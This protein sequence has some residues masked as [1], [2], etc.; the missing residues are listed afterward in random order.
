MFHRYANLLP[1]IATDFINRCRQS[2]EAKDEDGEDDTSWA[3]T[4]SVPGWTACSWVSF[5]LDL[6]WEPERSE[7]QKVITWVR[8]QAPTLYLWSTN[9]GL[10]QH[11]GDDD[12]T[13]ATELADMC[14]FA[15]AM[16]ANS[17]SYVLIVFGLDKMREAYR[18]VL[19]QSNLAFKAG[20]VQSIYWY[21]DNITSPSTFSIDNNMD[22]GLVAFFSQ[23]QKR[24]AVSF[25]ANA[26]S[27]RV[28]CHAFST[29]RLFKRAMDTGAL[30]KDQMS[31]PYLQQLLLNHTMEGDTVV[32]MCCG[33]GSLAVAG[34]TVGRNV[35]S[36]DKLDAAIQTS[37]AR[38]ECLRDR[39][40]K[41]GETD[42]LEVD[43]L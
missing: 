12:A 37:S 18:A 20:A 34:L 28:Q 25:P 13:T 17:L 16:A 4:V 29:Q 22:E 36:I 8:K 7:T 6:T 1:Q 3:V 19:E 40:Q 31:V 21:K 41:L 30:W 23:D 27:N 32:D 10:K 35:V 38:V 5:Q 42:V 14:R 33:A 15:H 26:D 39:V 11:P 24:T 43:T 9:Y 2:V